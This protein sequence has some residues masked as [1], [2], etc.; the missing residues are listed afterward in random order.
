MDATEQTAADKMG[1]EKPSRWRSWGPAFITAA[2]VVGP[3]TIVVASRIGAS[4]GTSLIWA[5]LMAGSFMMLFTTM[6]TRIGALNRQS[7]LSLVAT[8]YGRWLAVIVGFFAFVVTSSFQMGNYL[9]SS[10]AMTA[11]TGVRESVWMWVVGGLGLAIIF[12]ARQLYRLLE[13]IMLGLVFLMILAFVANL[14]AARPSPA[15]ILQGLVPGSWPKEM[16]PLLMAMVATTFSV[17]AALYQTTLAQQKG[18]GKEDLQIARRESI[19]GISALVLISLIVMITAATVLS[20]ASIEDATHLAEQLK[21]LL[22]NTAVVLF[23]LGFLSAAFSSTIVNAMIGGGLL[24]DGLGFRADV[25]G[26]PVRL[27]TALAML[28]GFSAGAYVLKTGSPLEGIILAQRTTLLA[29]PLCA[30]VMIL[31]ANNRKVV[32]AHGN[33]VPQNAW[34]LLALVILTI[35]SIIRLW[36]M[37]G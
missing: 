19:A 20:G 11:L 6:A 13:K 1:V 12:S 36:E 10:T 34:A 2:V 33:S 15:A 26:L 29:V 25:N 17:I 7:V 8:H 21:P 31:L 16:S 23:S 30:L 14:V 28:V 32:G 27:F 22:G 9:A 18:W 35:M 24:A 3:G 37:L 5:L 4:A